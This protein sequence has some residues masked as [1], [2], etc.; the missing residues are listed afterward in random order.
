MRRQQQDS[1]GVEENEDEVILDN[2]A[3]HPF[4]QMELNDLVRD[5]GLSKS[6]ADLVTS[7]L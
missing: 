5:L 6:S 7:R 1:S 2:D 3:P 4:P